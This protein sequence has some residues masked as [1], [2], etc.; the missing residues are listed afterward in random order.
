MIPSYGDNLH[1]VVADSGYESSE[2]YTYLK[3]KNLVAYINPANH[4]LQKKKK[5]K[6]NIGRENRLL[7]LLLQ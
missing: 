4:E 2:N 3:E 5:I 6:D 7:V 1:K